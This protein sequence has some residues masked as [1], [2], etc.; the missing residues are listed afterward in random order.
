[1]VGP[2]TLRCVVVVSALRTDT[3]RRLKRGVRTALQVC[4]S[5]WG[6]VQQCTGSE[7]RAMPAISARWLAGTGQRRTDLVTLSILWG[8][9]TKACA[10]FRLGRLRTVPESS[11]TGPAVGILQLCAKI[12]LL[13]TRV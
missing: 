1:M 3:A 2:V 13:K 12:F 9:L 7:G 4:A 10:V 6:H 11:A 5:W 8:F